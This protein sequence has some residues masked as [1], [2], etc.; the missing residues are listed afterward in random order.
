MSETTTP[1]NKPHLPAF[2]CDI[3]T[4]GRS[5]FEGIRWLIVSALILGLVGLHW[6]L[7]NTPGMWHGVHIGLRTLFLVPAVLAAVW[8]GLR[9][10]LLAAGAL[11]LLYAPH[12]VIA[13]SGRI[14]E[15]LGQVSTLIAIWVVA[16]VAGGFVDRERRALKHA[17]SISGGALAALIAALDAREHQTEAHSRRVAEL[18][19]QTAQRLGMTGPALRTCAQAAALHDIGKIGV[20]DHVLLKPGPLT[21]VERGQIEHHAQQG[22]EILSAAPHLQAAAELVLAHHERF[23]GTGYPRG[24]AGDQIPLGARIFAVADVFDALTSDRPY[25]DA[26][27]RAQAAQM[28]VEQRGRHFDPQ[29]VDAFLDVIQT[30]SEH[31]PRTVIDASFTRSATAEASVIA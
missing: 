20:P 13:W 29:V 2:G 14:T 27:S 22:Y 30:H 10:G 26:M 15:N 16:V 3:E 18:T 23:D 8:F 28:I 17:A 4:G 21:E 7:P 19:C 25:R 6:V 5:R 1:N 12:L 24:L 31:Q 9:G 11:T